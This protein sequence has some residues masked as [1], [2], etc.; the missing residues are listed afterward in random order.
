VKRMTLLFSFARPPATRAKTPNEAMH[1]MS[2]TI[3]PEAA[4]N[5]R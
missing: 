5:R 3:I 2:D 4:A 1:R